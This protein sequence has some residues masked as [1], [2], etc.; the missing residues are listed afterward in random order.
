MKSLSLVEYVLSRLLLLRCSLCRCDCLAILRPPVLSRSIGGP[1]QS[2]PPDAVASAGSGL[3][4]TCVRQN[5]EYLAGPALHGRG[6]GTS[7]EYH[8]A[9][10]IARKLKQYGIAPAAR[11][12]AVHPNRERAIA[13]GDEGADTLIHARERPQVRKPSRGHTEN[14]LL[15]CGSRNRRC[16]GLCRSWTWRTAG[17]FRGLAEGWCRS[18]AED[19]P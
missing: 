3:C 1:G 9:E 13:R 14:R 16:R 15:S 4:A 8:A 17:I 6:S 7:D 12:R 11:E 2:A 19:Q 5:L 18:V 10:F